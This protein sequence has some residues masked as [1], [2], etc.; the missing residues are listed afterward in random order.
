M[1]NIIYIF[2]Y[3]ILKFSW[4]SKYKID[5]QAKYCFQFKYDS[6]NLF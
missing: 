2:E 6:I 1:G 5:I 3:N 4:E